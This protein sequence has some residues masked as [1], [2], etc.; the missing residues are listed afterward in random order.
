MQLLRLDEAKWPATAAA[1]VGDAVD[2]V[3]DVGGAVRA[4]SSMDDGLCWW[5][6]RLEDGWS[7]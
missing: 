7:C 5:H 2:V 4:P 6:R 3:A 1:P